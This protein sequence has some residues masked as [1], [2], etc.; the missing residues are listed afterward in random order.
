MLKALRPEIV[1]VC[2]RHPDQHR[3]MVLAAIECGARGIYVEK[4]FCRTPEEA[5]QILAACENRGVKVAVAHRNRYHPALAAVKRL[6]DEGAIGRLLEFRGRGKEDERGGGEDLWVLGAHVCNLAH[7]LGGDPLG[8]SARIEQDG[9][10]V[11]HA[12]ISDGKEGLGPLAGDTVH[13]RY[14]MKC[15]VPFYFDSIRKAGAKEVGFGLQIVGN[16]GVIDLRVDAH[17]MA[18]LI[19]GNP[20]LPHTG[21]RAWVPISSAGP[22]KPEPIAD[23]PML[24]EKHVLPGRDLIAAIREGRAPLCDAQQGAM[25]VDMICAA[26][27]SH[28]EGGRRVAI[29]LEDRSSPMG[30]F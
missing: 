3:D 20:F 26:F 8:C 14:D 7:H 27:E 21:P 6:L 30:R 9:H 5:D 1:A 2:P 13:A 12:D 17:P 24:V 23:L 29:P 18:H 19:E 16:R 28:R 15:G 10:P 4:P 25:T 11:T 22:G